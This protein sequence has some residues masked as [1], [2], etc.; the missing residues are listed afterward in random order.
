M[1]RELLSR[2]GK[3]A[4]RQRCCH[5]RSSKTQTY[6]RMFTN[7]CTC[8]SYDLYG[9][10]LMFEKSSRKSRSARRSYHMIQAVHTFQLP[11][12]FLEREISHPK[13]IGALRNQSTATN[14]ICAWC[15][16]CCSHQKPFRSLSSLPSNA[17]SLQPVFCTPPVSERSRSTRSF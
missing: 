1:V 13:L 8:T 2:H 3:A 17:R 5:G 9:C 6:T 14:F 4:E 16:L 7:T 10:D 11:S 15:V 12:L